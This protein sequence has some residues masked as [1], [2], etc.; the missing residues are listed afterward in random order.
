ML[1]DKLLK[2]AEDVSGAIRQTPEY[3]AFTLQKKKVA[4]DPEAKDLIE[5]ARD[6]QSR[7]M[8]IPESERNSDYAES[9]QDQYEEISENTAVFDYTRA[10]ATYMTMVQEV[11]GTIIENLEV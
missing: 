8:D 5:K 10:E 9:L 3:E 7:L 11:L 1:S 6:I 4:S 2:L